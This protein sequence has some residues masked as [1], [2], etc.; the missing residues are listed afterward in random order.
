MGRKRVIIVSAVFPP[1]QVTSALLNYDL[2]K[3]LAKENKVTVL[4]P[5]PTR[6]IGAEFKECW[7]DPDFET[8]LV[9]SYTHP[10]SE[11][12]GRFKESNDFGRK[13]VAYIKEHHNEIDF[14][15]NDGWQLFG[16]YKVA[17][18]CKRY[19]I[20]YM[21]PIQDIYPECLLTK[22]HIPVFAKSLIEGILRPTVQ[23]EASVLILALPAG[24]G[25]LCLPSKLTSYLLSGRPVLA[26]VDQDSSTKR[27]LEGEGC[28]KTV[29]PDDKIALIEGFQSFARMSTE[30]LTLMGKKSRDYALTHLTREVNLSIV[31]E[32]IKQL[33]Q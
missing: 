26:S 3:S 9:D 8:V 24:N 23:S 7:N 30:E 19:G 10:E 14:V 22:A 12:I 20:P 2:A 28:G 27:I 29:V 25:N 31:L 17:K 11:L 1:E 16:L 4:R 15:Y 6:P 32:S 33:L 18:V 21:V 13:S 5:R